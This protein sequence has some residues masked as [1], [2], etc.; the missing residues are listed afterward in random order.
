MAILK[1]TGA[2][3]LV[4]DDLFEH[5]NKFRWHNAYGWGGHPCIKRRILGV[6]PR[7]SIAIHHE[8]LGIDPLDLK[9]SVVDHINRNPLDN[10]RENLRVVSKSENALNSIR[11]IKAKAVYYEKSRNRW[12]AF[13]LLPHKTRIYLGSFRTE[14]EAVVAHEQVWL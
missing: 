14:A 7:R 3:T 10:R 11:S 1:V 6:K 12:K 9:G 4:D 5:L 13:L 2:E 8:V